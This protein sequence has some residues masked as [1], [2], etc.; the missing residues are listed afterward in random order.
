MTTK[1][2]RIPYGIADYGRLRRDNMY[3]V[4]QTA[5]IPLIEA[6]PYYLFF[7]RPRRFGKSLW[8]S[9]L[10]YYY[11]VGL[12]GQFEELFGDTCVGQHPTGEHSSYMVLSFNF[13]RVNPDPAKVAASFNAHIENRLFFFGEQYREFLGQD[14]FEAMARYSEA[15]QK[16]QFLLHAEIVQYIVSY[17][18]LFFESN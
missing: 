5:F 15:Y 16:L 1:P 13:L 9:L 3:Y 6:A 14:Y 8:L 2:K 4:D 11:D 17:A 7:I 10:Q 18:A 12:T